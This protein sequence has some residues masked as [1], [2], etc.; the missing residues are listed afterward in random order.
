MT[1]C[2]DMMMAIC[3]NRNG[4]KGRT[5]LLK[6]CRT[7][8]EPYACVASLLTLELNRENTAVTSFSRGHACS[9]KTTIP[10]KAAL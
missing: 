10:D 8:T 4:P 6:H 2:S 1:N 5:Y 9:S 3:S 7:L